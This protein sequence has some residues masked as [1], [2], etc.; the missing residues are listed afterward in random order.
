[1]DD[2]HINE[3][4][5]PWW[6]DDLKLPQQQKRLVPMNSGDSTFG[7][8]EYNVIQP[9]DSNTLLDLLAKDMIP[10]DNLKFITWKDFDRALQNDADLFGKMI[11]LGHEGFGQ[12]KDDL[13][14]K[15]FVPL[16]GN[17]GH[18]DFVFYQDGNN[19]QLITNAD[20]HRMEYNVK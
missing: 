4:E 10:N 17:S 19:G 16:F 12:L 9:I 8:Y 20:K 15:K 18:D 14:Y 11:S 6:Q 2:S 5:V 3:L 13:S 7:F 1:M